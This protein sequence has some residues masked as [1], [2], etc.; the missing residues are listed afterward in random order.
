MVAAAKPEVNAAAGVF[1]ATEVGALGYMSRVQVPDTVQ[2]GT[3]AMASP[4]IQE[5]GDFSEKP[6][7][8]LTGVP[9]S[10]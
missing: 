8:F 3:A 2:R 1:V 6:P 5:A 4:V 10:N 9:R 7:P